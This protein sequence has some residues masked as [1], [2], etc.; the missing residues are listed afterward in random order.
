MDL[1]SAIKNDV[2]FDRASETSEIYEVYLEKISS[3]AAKLSRERLTR[4]SSGFFQTVQNG[5][6]INVKSCQKILEE[7]I[8][9]PVVLVQVVVQFALIR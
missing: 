6:S 1:S 8:K 3:F 4:F 7:R 2:I 9:E 5:S